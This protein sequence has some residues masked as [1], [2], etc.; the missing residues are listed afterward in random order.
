MGTTKKLRHG[1][2]LFVALIA[3]MTNA[4][5]N[6]DDNLL[7]SARAR[8]GAETSEEIKADQE[9]LNAR[10]KDAKA[11]FLKLL[12]D[13]DAGIPERLLKKSDCVS[14]MPSKKFCANFTGIIS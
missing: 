6:A 1:S 5:A 14:V 4:A 2:C 3:V 7:D 11:D 13:N 9:K 10:L 12:N 8:L